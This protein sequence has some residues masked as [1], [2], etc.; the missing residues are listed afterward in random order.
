M[1]VIKF[2][3]KPGCINNEKQKKLLREAGHELEDI[4]ILNHSWTKDYLRSFFGSEPV[5][6]WFNITAPAITRGGFKAEECSEEEAISAMIK[7]RLLIKRPL[8]EIGN[9]RFFGFSP[10]L[11]ETKIGGIA[12]AVEKTGSTIGSLDMTA[13]PHTD[14][15]NNCNQ[16]EPSWSVWLREGRQYLRAGSGKKNI[17]NN[18]ILYNL[19]AM[20]LEKFVMALLGYNMAMPVNHTFTDLLYSLEK[21]Y[22]LDSGLRETVLKLETKQEIC[23]FEDYVR[24]EISDEDIIIMRK[25]IKK[26]E[27]M[28][29]QVCIKATAPRI[30]FA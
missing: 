15:T 9:E 23:S 8:M 4:N 7:D 12:E 25:T 16:P 2:F 11:L 21:I 5:S 20:S 6:S 18:S 29:N 14:S 26:F 27:E 28:A 3:G 30:L 24:T 13:C 10:V 19:L 22:P 17:F 1:A